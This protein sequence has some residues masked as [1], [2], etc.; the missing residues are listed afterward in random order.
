ML[1][2]IIAYKYRTVLP[3]NFQNQFGRLHTQSKQNHA[4]ILIHYPVIVFYRKKGVALSRPFGQSNMLKTFCKISFNH[5]LLNSKGTMKNIKPLPR[6]NFLLNLVIFKWAWPCNASHD[7]DRTLAVHLRTP[8]CILTH[9]KKNFD[10]IFV[11]SRDIS[12]T[13]FCRQAYHMLCARGT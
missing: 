8:L 12:E 7:D 13:L 4:K 3:Q 6:S 9:C 11:H 1:V 5:C 10:K 2:R